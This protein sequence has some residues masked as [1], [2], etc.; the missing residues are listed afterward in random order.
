MADIDIQEKR[1]PGLWPWLIGLV[2]LALVVWGVVQYMDNDEDLVAT[3]TAEEQVTPAEPL[4][5]APATTGSASTQFLAWVRDSVNDGQ[6]MGREHEYT[7]DG[8]QRLH[9]A[10]DGLLARESA[11]DIRQR[12]DDLRERTRTIEQSDA[13]STEHATQVKQAFNAAVEALERLSELGQVQ[14]ADLDPH[15]GSARRAMDSI[16]ANRPLLD[17]RN[18]VRTFFENMGRA[19]EVAERRVTT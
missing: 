12:L 15:V 16:D 13:T 8:L 17:Q 7:R 18:A 3:T 19:I 14:R 6:R 10:L 11:P 1:G 5:P 4:A 9:A 2:A